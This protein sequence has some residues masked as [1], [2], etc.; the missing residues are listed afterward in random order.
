LPG[1]PVVKLF[2]IATVFVSRSEARRLLHGLDADFEVVE[3]DFTGVEDVD[4]DLLTNYYGCGR[5]PIPARGSCR[6]T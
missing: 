3:V 2:E 4:K 5:L 1:N 6:S